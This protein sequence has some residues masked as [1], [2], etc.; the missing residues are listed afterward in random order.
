MTMSDSEKLVQ[1]IRSLPEFVIYTTIDGDYNHIGATVADA[2]L[3]ANNRYATNVKPRVQR[4]LET[5]PLAETTSSVLC[6]LKEIR[7]TEFL[8]WR[9]EDRAEC[10]C[11]VLEL[12]AS[13]HI[14]SEVDLRAWLLENANLPK[15]R[16]IKGIG[17]KTVDYFKILVGVS[18]SAIDRHLFNFLGLAGLSPCGYSEAQAI[19]NSAADILLVDRAYFDHSI[20]QFMSKR[21]AQPGITECE[22]FKD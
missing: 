2:I 21:V 4:I 14:E 1:Y 13:E 3:Q 15:L 18:T 17:P 22:G 6:L 12:F 7:A 16:S 10:F 9:G 19:I 5:Y 20:W 8:S 11:R